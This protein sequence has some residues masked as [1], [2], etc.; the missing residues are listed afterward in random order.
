MPVEMRLGVP[1][2]RVVDSG[3]VRSALDGSGCCL[4][5]RQKGAGLFGG[6]ILQ[7]FCV[8]VEHEQRPAR[9]PC[10]VVQTERDNLQTRNRQ[11]QLEPTCGADGIVHENAWSFKQMVSR[12]TRA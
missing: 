11:P 7:V 3:T 4:C 2:D 5:I 1:Q 8:I 12:D 10:V 6:Y 9:E